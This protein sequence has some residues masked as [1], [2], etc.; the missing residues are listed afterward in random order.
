M[1]CKREPQPVKNLLLLADVVEKP[2]KTVL[3]GENDKDATSFGSAHLKVPDRSQ[4]SLMDLPDEIILQVTTLLETDLVVSEDDGWCLRQATY[5]SRDA[6]TSRYRYYKAIQPLHGLILTCRR[7]YRISHASLYRSVS[8]VQPLQS[9]LID[10]S[11]YSPLS[12]FVATTIKRPE[13]HGKVLS[14]SVWLRKASDAPVVGASNGNE[15][16]HCGRELETFLSSS[17]FRGGEH[18]EWTR[19]LKRPTDA[20]LSSLALATL[21]NL[22]K[23]RILGQKLDGLHEHAFRQDLEHLSRGL[24]KTHPTTLSL[25]GPIEHISSKFPNVTHWIFD[26]FFEERAFLTHGSA[27]RNLSTIELRASRLNNDDYF[28]TDPSTQYRLNTLLSSLPRL[29]VLDMGAVF[30]T[31]AIRIPDHVE[32]LIMRWVNNFFLDQ[33]RFVMILAPWILCDANSPLIV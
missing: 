8:L 23:A 15:L 13:L 26:W 5:H 18:E 31:L 17:P 33:L 25:S 14:L 21:P 3:E 2:V 30:F 28:Q 4:T 24:A 22:Q 19:D 12:S 32:T 16:Y 11:L 29:R 1:A 9:R 6:Y 10:S 20:M 27:F 7:L